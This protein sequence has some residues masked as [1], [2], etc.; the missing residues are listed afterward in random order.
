MDTNSN[1]GEWLW[2]PLA[3]LKLSAMSEIPESKA[4]AP[5][6]YLPKDMKTLGCDQQM[7]DFKVKYVDSICGIAILLCLTYH[8]SLQYNP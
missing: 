3:A 2:Q 4:K 5:I 7:K 1:Q 8:I 6:L